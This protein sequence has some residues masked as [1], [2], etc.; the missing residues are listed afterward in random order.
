IEVRTA[1]L[2]ALAEAVDPARTKLVAC[3]HVSWV[4]GRLA[5]AALAEVG[6]EIPVL[7]DG[8]QGVGAVPVDLEAL[9]CAFYAGAGQKWLCGPVGTGMLWVAPAWRDRLPA[10][11]ATYLNL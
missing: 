10:L 9:G 2:E 11:G 1:P 5:P 3:S 4:T 8:A 6:R 7:L